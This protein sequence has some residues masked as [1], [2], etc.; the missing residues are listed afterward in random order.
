MSIYKRVPSNKRSL[1]ELAKRP[2][3]YSWEWKYAAEEEL[4]YVSKLSAKDLLAY[5]QERE[6]EVFIDNI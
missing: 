1:R 4:N 5:R 2:K 6:E 3:Y